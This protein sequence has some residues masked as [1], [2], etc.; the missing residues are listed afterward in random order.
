MERDC[1][2]AV[3]G[4]ES[5]FDAVAV[6]DVNVD[7]EDTLVVLEELQDAEDNVVDVA[8]ARGLALFGVVKAASPVDACVCLTMVE[9]SGTG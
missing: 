1:H 5:F 8:K 2:D 6:V 4:V 3:G 9:L 7:V